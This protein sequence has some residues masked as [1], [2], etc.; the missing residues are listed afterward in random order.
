MSATL[1]P[2]PGLELPGHMDL[3]ETDGSVVE[4]GLEQFQ[5]A[6]LTDSIEPLLARTH[7]DGQYFIGQDVGI[8]FR[9]TD[10]PLR[11]CKAPDW[12]YVPNV[13]PKAPDG[14]DR[15]SFVMWR[16]PKVPPYLIVE[17]VS[18]DGEEERD[19]TPETG[20]FWVYEKVVKAQIYAIYDGFQGTLECYTR[21][22]GEYVR[23]EPNIR[24]RY[25]L[26]RL[27]IELGLWRGRAHNTERVWLRFFDAS[28]ALIPTGFELAAREANR[29]DE[30]ANRAAQE[31]AAREAAEAEVVRLKAKLAEL[32]IDPTKL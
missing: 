20:K 16:E 21:L 30:E 2:L 8:Y 22:S 4:N 27:N 6:M 28:G 29:A 14:H 18:G 5:N 7:P 26:P 19:R 11:G 10:P 3:P 15:R 31:R 23:L 1:P 17:Q 24:G 13:P 9:H 12:Y 32:G 25:E